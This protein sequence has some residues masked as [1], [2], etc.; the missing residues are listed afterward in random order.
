MTKVMYDVPSDPTISAVTITP[1]CIVD[2]AAPLVE[3][4]E[5]RTVRPK[6][7]AAALH[8]ERGGLNTKG[9]VS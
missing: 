8:A 6:P 5:S 4:D 2:H 1:E 3:H 7:G 9:N